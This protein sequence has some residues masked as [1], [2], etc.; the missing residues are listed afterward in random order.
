MFGCR[1]C[2]WPCLSRE[3]LEPS[4]D[5]LGEIVTV[6]VT[7]SLWCQGEPW[8][9]V[10][11]AGGDSVPLSRGV[12]CGSREQ[13]WVCWSWGWH[14]SGGLRGMQVESLAAVVVVVWFFCPIW[15]GLG[16]V[17][18]SLLLSLPPSHSFSFASLCLRLPPSWAAGLWHPSAPYGVQV[19]GHVLGGE[20][21]PL[22]ASVGI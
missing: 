18:L 22:S 7:R 11:D 10:P 4:G 12:S 13:G 8:P 21:L 6:I 17:S 9:L 1:C 16:L 15:L 3:G 5:G 2:D 20:E 19:L 14:V